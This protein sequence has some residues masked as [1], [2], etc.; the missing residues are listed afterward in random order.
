M[1]EPLRLPERLVFYLGGIMRIGIIGRGT[2]GGALQRGFERHPEV[3]EI[4]A[5]TRA[6][7][8][9]NRDV[10]AE[11][12]IVV[13]CV[14]PKDAN[15]V[16]TQI[17]PV[18][19]E[20][21]VLISAIAAVDTAMLRAWT[22]DRSPVVRVMPNTPARV[23]A[24]MTVLA[25]TKESDD[26]VLARAR[27]LFDAFGKTL[28]LDES[29]MDAVTAVSGCG[30]AFVFV[31]IEAMIDAAVALG[32]PYDEARV[33]VAQ[34]VLG[35]G[36]LVLESGAHPGALKHEVTTPAGRTIKGLV[37][38]ENGNLRAALINAVLAAGTR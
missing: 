26:G 15:D 7:A 33:L 34:T 21:H 16:C 8:F 12:D 13:V 28:V 37:E 25:R 3:K 27:S 4:D 32:V 19:R 30:P 20:D 23:A 1:N 22:A 29:L 24:A 17:A 9:R 38:L 10:A 6:S 11:S 5:T 18:L 2:L 14:K 35:S 31:A 36:R